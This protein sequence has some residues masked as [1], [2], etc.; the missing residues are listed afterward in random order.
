MPRPQIDLDHFKAEILLRIAAGNSKKDIRQWLAANGLDISK[1]T[2]STRVLEWQGKPTQIPSVDVRLVSEV[3][4][5][6]HTTAHDD[7]TI[8]ANVTA[9]G[10][11]TTHRQVKRIRLAHGWRRR[12]DTDDQLAESRAKTFALVKAALHQGVVRCYGRGLLRTYLRLAYGHQTHEDD[13]RDA[14]ATTQR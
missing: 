1:N 3:D 7:E 6:F 12:S 8:A 2:L 10:I 13:V 4:S 14:L 9:L 5:A 11:P